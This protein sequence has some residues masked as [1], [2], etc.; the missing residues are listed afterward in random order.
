MYI[1][2]GILG[3]AAIYLLVLLVCCLAGM[4]IAGT[5]NPALWDQGTRNGVVGASVAVFF[6]VMM[7]LGKED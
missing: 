3:L 6:F 2:K 5:W 1:I 7:G 4:V